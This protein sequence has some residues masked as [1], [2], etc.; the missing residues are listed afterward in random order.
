M[1]SY[2]YMVSQFHTSSIHAECHYRLLWRL[3]LSIVNQVKDMGFHPSKH[4]FVEAIRVLSS[5]SSSTWERKIEA[6]R[7]YGWSEDQTLLAFKKYPPCLVIS[8]ENIYKTMDFFVHKMRFK[9]EDI[10][11]NP[12]VMIYSLEKRIIPRCSVVQSLYSKGLL[13]KKLSITSIVRPAEKTFLEKYVTK[14]AEHVTWLL[15]LYA[16][17]IKVF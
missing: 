14:F 5:M 2:N 10:A 3:R 4:V 15:Q 17:E 8:E 11:T 13:K 1:G 16:G 9:P 12:S 6:Y 7:K